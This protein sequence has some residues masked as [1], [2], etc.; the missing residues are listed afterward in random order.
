MAKKVLTD[1]TATG[2]VTATKGIDLSGANSPI[3]L[4][5]SLGTS[6]QLLQSTG[7]GTT[8]TWVNPTLS[9]TY[10]ASTTSAQLAGVVSDETG[11]GSLVFGTSPTFTTPRIANSVGTAT[12][13]MIDYNGE[14]FMLTTTGTSTGKGTVLAPAW[15]YSNAN[16]TQATGSTAQSIFQSGARALPLE[17]GKTYYFKL[18][19]AWSHAWTSGGPN[20][21][22]LDPTFSQVPQEINYLVR[23]ATSSA[24]AFSARAT[25]T[26]ATSIASS[27]STNGQTGV[28]TIEGFFR[29]NATTGGTV[30][31]KYSTNSGG[32]GGFTML[33]G[34][35]QQIMKI[36]SGAAGI[37]SGSWA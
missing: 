24:G 11:S 19:L 32:T 20:T 28:T 35:Y 29:S 25:V 30:E 16:A 36:G 1:I 26:T 12:S 22:R 5:G 17:A 8:P 3:Q 34:C 31:F 23:T 37:V 10:M 2:S 27:T 14:V 21:L 7:A 33:A 15:A 9:S 18:L 13:G 4:N 6:G